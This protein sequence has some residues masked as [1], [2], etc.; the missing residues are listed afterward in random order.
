MLCS[1]Q[2]E[3]CIVCLKIPAK[4]GNFVSKNAD[5]IV[6]YKNDHNILCF[7]TIDKHNILWYYYFVIIA[8]PADAGGFYR[9]QKIFTLPIIASVIR[10]L[11]TFS[12]ITHRTG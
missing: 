11:L 7:L 2:A 6:V 8:P 5:F 10:L 1:L 9:M 3:F 4:A 12:G